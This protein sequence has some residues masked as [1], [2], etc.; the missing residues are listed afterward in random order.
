ME[1]ETGG[2]GL[3]DQTTV[4]IVRSILGEI[5]ELDADV[6]DQL[7]RTTTLEDLRVH[8][9]DSLALIETIEGLERILEIKLGDDERLADLKNL[10]DVIDWVDEL[11]PTQNGTS[12]DAA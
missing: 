12:P 8:G 1:R 2:E 4:Q 6:A 5:L 9:A 10:G 7:G 11:T 3:Q